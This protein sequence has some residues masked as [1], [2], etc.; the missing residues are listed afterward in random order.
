MNDNHDAQGR[1]AAAQAEVNAAHEALMKSQGN[2]E[3]KAA[4]ERYYQATKAMSDLQRGVTAGHQAAHEREVAQP[5]R[6]SHRDLYP[7]Q[8]DH[9]LVGKRVSPVGSKSSFVVERVV[10]SRFGDLAVHSGGR[11]AHLVSQVRE[12]TSRNRG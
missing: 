5:L 8:Y 11:E 6:Q 10:G 12:K 3:N 4:N 2:K 7:G 1:F 9:P